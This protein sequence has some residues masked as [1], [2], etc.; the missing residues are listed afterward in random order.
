MVDLMIGLLLTM[1]WI[2]ILVQRASQC[3]RNCL[4]TTADTQN[5]NISLIGLL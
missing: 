5:R 1:W 3:H 4:M 2:E